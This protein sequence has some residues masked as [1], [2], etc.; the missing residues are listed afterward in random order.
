[1]SPLTIAD[2]HHRYETA[3]R[4]QA[5]QRARGAD[6]DVAGRGSDFVL[7]LLLE[8]DAGPLLVLPTHRVVRGL[9]DAGP[10]LWT[11]LRELFDIEEDVSRERLLDEF[12]PGGAGTPGGAGRFGLWTRAGGSILHVRRTA[13]EPHLP[14]GGPAVRRL[15]VTLL[16][17]ALE[18][19][20]GLDA[21]TVAGGDRLTYTKDAEEA[22]AMV[23][24]P[25]GG[26]DAAFLLDGTPAGEII[27]VAAQGDVMPQKSTY[28]YPK[29]LTGLV[30]NP[31]E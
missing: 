21:E 26:A 17:A 4:F 28:I 15:D 13:I 1:M 20:A 6:P 16:G 5:E 18:A 3:L 24:A 9:G 25:T 19:C 12:G 14:A 23:D 31:L 7:M 27:A 10:R 22:I 11:G 8:P 30:I 29:A 2:G